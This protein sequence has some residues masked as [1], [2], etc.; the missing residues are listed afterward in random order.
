LPETTMSNPTHTAKAEPNAANMC[1]GLIA[2][3]TS[4]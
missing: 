4:T 1:P 3:V 2:T